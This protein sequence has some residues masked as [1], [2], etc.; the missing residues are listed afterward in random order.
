M[1]IPIEID[2]A[3]LDEAQRLS[4]L[5]TREATAE[6]A[7]RLLIRLRGHTDIIGLAG[8]IIMTGDLSVVPY[9]PDAV[10]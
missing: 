4:R 5:P 3:L 2:D 9:D 8:D 10:W 6:A 7:L 1:L